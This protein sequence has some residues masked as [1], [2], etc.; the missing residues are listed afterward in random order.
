MN[1][2]DLSIVGALLTLP[3]FGENLLGIDGGLR[4]ITKSKTL[5][6]KSYNMLRIGVMLA[7]KMQ[8]TEWD[9]VAAIIVMGMMQNCPDLSDEELENAFR[10]AKKLAPMIPKLLKHVDEIKSKLEGK[11]KGGKVDA[12][13][14]SEAADVPTDN[15]TT[16]TTTMDKGPDATATATTIDDIK[17]MTEFL[18]KL[19]KDMKEES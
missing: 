14:V 1:A 9:D 13:S 10:Q 8:R 18:K 19:S 17:R 4:E 5:K 6:E 12:G 15:N 2:L 11:E 3:D 16:T 7:L